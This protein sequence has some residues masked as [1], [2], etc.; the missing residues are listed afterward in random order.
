[1]NKRIPGFDGQKL[2]EGFL[3]RMGM[4]RLSFMGQEVLEALNDDDV[5]WTTT[6]RSLV[7][8]KHGISLQM[9]NGFFGFDTIDGDGLTDLTLWDSFALW[10][11]ARRLRW[12][13]R[14][15]HRMEMIKNYQLNEEALAKQKAYQAEYIRIHNLQGEFNDV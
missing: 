13:L 3:E 8:K 14:H 10:P 1:M 9:G 12:R 6:S 11:K 5:T 2:K 7:N 15:Y 4:K